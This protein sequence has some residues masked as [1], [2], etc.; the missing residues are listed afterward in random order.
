MTGWVPLIQ[1]IEFRVFV[2]WIFELI[3]DIVPRDLDC[4]CLIRVGC[5]LVLVL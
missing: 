1:L 3:P 4:T 2:G 5:N